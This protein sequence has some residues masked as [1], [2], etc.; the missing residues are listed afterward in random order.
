MDTTIATRQL[1]SRL[2]LRISS[3]CD[4]GDRRRGNLD[5]IR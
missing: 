4:R 5:V 3:V 1:P 2:V